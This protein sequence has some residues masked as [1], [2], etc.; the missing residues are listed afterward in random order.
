MYNHIDG[1]DGHDG[2][3]H[4]VKCLVKQFRAF[5]IAPQQTA[6]QVPVDRASS[7]KAVVMLY[8]R[9][10]GARYSG[11]LLISNCLQAATAK[12]V[13]PVKAIALNRRT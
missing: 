11:Q 2:T 3:G 6:L 8:S 13:L 4:P 7:Y 10:Q 5:N 9:R 12:A 1:D